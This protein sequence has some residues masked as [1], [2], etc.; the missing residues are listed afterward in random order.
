MS[1]RLCHKVAPNGLRHRPR[2]VAEWDREAWRWGKRGLSLGAGKTRSQ[3]NA[4]KY[5]RS[6]EGAVHCDHRPPQVRERWGSPHTKCDG[7]H[8][9]GQSLMTFKS[10]LCCT[11][12]TDNALWNQVERKDRLNQFNLHH[13][14]LT[15]HSNKIQA[16]VQEIR[17]ESI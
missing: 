9:P 4:R 7:A 10:C 16:S 17:R 3:K 11:Y 8:Y 5:R 1:K 13:G 15:I 14:Q 6:G 2:G 12:Q